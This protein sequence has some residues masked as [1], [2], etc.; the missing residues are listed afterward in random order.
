MLCDCRR[1]TCTWA[2]SENLLIW[3][4]AQWFCLNDSSSLYFPTGN[5][6]NPLKQWFWD[7]LLQEFIQAEH[8]N[9]FKKSLDK[10]KKG[11]SIDLCFWMEREVRDVNYPYLWHYHSESP[12]LWA[13]FS[14]LPNLIS[15]VL[16]VQTYNEVTDSTYIWDSFSLR[17]SC[18]SKWC[19]H[20]C[21]HKISD[22]EW[23]F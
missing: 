17:P 10:L 3:P 5:T 21:H 13:L 9:R 19:C 15:Y 20:S 22:K 12:S 7:S 4:A 18:V 6:I 1:S 8:I 11:R 2:G 14:D 23:R 16:G